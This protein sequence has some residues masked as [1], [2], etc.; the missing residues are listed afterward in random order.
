MPCYEVSRLAWEI[1]VAAMQMMFPTVPPAAVHNP[2]SSASPNGVISPPRGL[3]TA[4]RRF[5]LSSQP[6]NN[7][8]DGI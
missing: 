5:Q 1:S 7:T 4:S 6:H 3:M 2:D 8:C